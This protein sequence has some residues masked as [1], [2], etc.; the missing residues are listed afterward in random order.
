M[1]QISDLRNYSFMNVNEYINTIMQYTEYPSSYIIP[2]SDNEYINEQILL[3]D[4]IL[5]EHVFPKFVDQKEPTIYEIISYNK[6]YY[7]YRIIT[8]CNL[9]LGKFE[10]CGKTCES[11]DFYLSKLLLIQLI[12]NLGDYITLRD[13]ETL[14]IGYSDS[15]HLIFRNNIQRLYME[16]LPMKDDYNFPRYLYRI[17]NIRNF[18]TRS[19]HNIMDKIIV[20]DQYIPADSSA[21]LLT[22][23]H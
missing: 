8:L 6:Y 11:V 2:K 15:G 7:T 4:P 18:V 14:I 20:D 16:V 3:R 10:N 5:F 19:I 9:I 21:I 23:R 12:K 22:K 17:E 13:I 1:S